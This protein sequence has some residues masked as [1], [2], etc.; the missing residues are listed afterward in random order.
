MSTAKKITSQITGYKVKKANETATEAPAEVAMT[1]VV[2]MHE[3]IA[4][5]EV[6]MGSTYKIKE[7]TSEHALYLTI[8]DIVLNQGT[9]NEVRRPFEIFVNSKNMDH[10]MWI[11]ALTRMVSAVFRKGGD[12]T[13]IV[14]EF[15]QVFD[16]TGGYFIPNT[17]GKRAN[18][19]IHHIGMKL[20][21]HMTLIG[22]IKK[23]ELDVHQQK[24]VD[25]KR[26][27]FE[28]TTAKAQSSSSEFPEGATNCYKCDEKAMIV[29]DG[30]QTCL[31]CG[32]SKC[33]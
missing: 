30:C 4:R 18:S 17:G 13:F 33:Q 32:E 31:N 12:V 11:T 24:L 3:S 28:A 16:T 23:P 7:P 2:E 1:N 14:E 29:M 10:F 20:E 21:E 6:L 26:A 27:Q 22:L 5:E 25:E 19:L 9:D 8:N 15:K